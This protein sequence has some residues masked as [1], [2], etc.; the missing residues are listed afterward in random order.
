MEVSYNNDN[1]EWKHMEAYYNNNSSEWKY[2][3]QNNSEW[4]YTENNNSE[5]KYASTI[6]NNNNFMEIFYYHGG[7]NMYINKFI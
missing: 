2:T 4:T 7:K 5:W 1:S 3:K 6:L